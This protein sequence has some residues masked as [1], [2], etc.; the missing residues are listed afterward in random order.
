MAL[1]PPHLAERTRA[2]PAG[3]AADERPGERPEGAFVLCWLRCA[4]R[5]EENPALDAALHLAG[6]QGLPVLVYLGLS[7]R[8]GW[9]SDR[10]HAFQLQAMR[11]LV[12]ALR[13]RGVPAVVHVE[14]PGHRGPVLRQLVSRAAAVVL[15]DVP[16]G[17][18]HSWAERLARACPAPVLAVDAA[19]VVPMEVVGRAYDR[20]FAYREATAAERRARVSAPWS[21]APAPTAAPGSTALPALPF[22][23]VELE[24]QDDAALARLI[25]SCEIDHS[26]PAVRETRG[27]SSA[28]LERWRRFRERGLR[29]YAR[30]RNDPLL[31][32][33]SRMSAYLHFG[34]VSPLRLAREAAAQGGPGA[35][36][37]LDELLTWR[38]LAWSFCRFTPGADTLAALPEWARRTLQAHEGDPRPLKSWEQLSSA[39]SGD[40]LWDACQRSLLRH[41]ELHNNLRMTWG[42]AVVGWS[43][44]AAA[45]LETLVELNHRYAL[46]GRDPASLGGILWCLGQFDRSFSPELP[47][48][49]AVRP[50]P[51]AGHAA[52]LEV[53]ALQTS[54]AR[55]ARPG[56]Q[57]VAVVGAGISGLACA[58]VLAEQGVEVTLFDKGRG[59]GGRLATRR[60]E[61]FSFDHGAQFFT[62]KDPGFAR[63]VRSWLEQ[64]VV[65][66]WS[67]R[68][69]EISLGPAGRGQRVRPR[70]HPRYVAQPGMS[71]LAR[72]LAEGLDLRQGIRVEA[73]SRAQDG[74]WL[75]CASAAAADSTAREGPFDAVALALPAPQA[76]PLVEALAPALLPEVLRAR[77]TPC[78]ALLA[79]WDAPLAVEFDAATV[80]G[81][82]L[83]WA[84]RSASKP[85]RGGSEGWVAHA[86]AAWSEAHL[87]RPA[88][89]LVPLLAAALSEA[90][91]A[92]LPAPR[93]LEAH[94]WRYALAA[95]P[96]ASGCLFD[97]AAMVGACGDWCNGP[98]VESAWLSGVALAGRLLG[99]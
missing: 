20:A 48:L 64:G 52:R 94:R 13:A 25:A 99:G 32:G 15:D 44:D 62:A 66:P 30:D 67:P 37:F 97:P 29:Q 43:R 47:V 89:E 31:P 57:R 10:L 71:A 50:R 81:S 45:A 75:T 34:C 39:Q 92:P 42:K 60:A 3:G 24:A 77:L 27:G 2:L 46:D 4:L 36:K 87:E 56:P 41:G 9:A 59:P 12:G 74:L 91:G 86:S 95:V 23:P 55:P 22:E 85:G 58:R 49:G 6:A 14:R 82:P 98:R 65:A 90:L 70:E 63:R 38:E 16:L 11:E 28:G 53:P 72:H 19:C 78:H 73:A 76:A 83:A 84:A 54:V 69:V 18:L 79:G 51:L 33:V 93:F 80:L 5:A 7:E 40:A 35:E 68:E 8:S 21:E 61:G 26:V 1:L 96:L 17:F 88:A